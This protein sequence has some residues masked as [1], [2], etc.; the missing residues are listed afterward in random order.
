MSEFD[1]LARVME[2]RLDPLADSTLGRLR[3]RVPAWMLETA[4]SRDEIHDFARASLRTQLHSFRSGVLPES[5]PEVDAAGAMAVAKMGE[6]KVLLNAYRV[7]QMSLWEAWL[8]LVEASVEGAEQRHKLLTR[9]SEFFSRYAGLLSDYVADIYQ[10][11]LEHAARD[12]G[13]RRLHAIRG[14]LEGKPLAVSGLDLNLDQYH[15]GLVAWGEAGEAAARELA[16]TLGRLLLIVEPMNRTW[17]GW[18][19]GARPFDRTEERKLESFRPSSRASIALGLPAFG[20]TG[21]RAT[22]HQAQRARW[23]GG[24]AELSVIRYA[25]VAIESLAG[26]NQEDARAF[27][28]REL[29]GISDDSTASKRLRETLTAYFAAGNNAASAAATLG[30]HQQTVANRLRT[31]EDRLG[32]PIGARRIELEVALRL[33]AAMNFTDSQALRN[34]CCPLRNICV[35]GSECTGDPF[36]TVQ[37]GQ[38]FPG[39]T[40]KS[41][42]PVAP[43]S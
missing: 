43:A 11:E 41:K 33:R 30:V 35:A 25:D 28:D 17:W 14:L 15:L 9:G 21:F 29:R 10:R 34:P 8:D 7:C 37:G 13:G 4:F 27:V 22:H 2:A 12:A 20:E 39:G 31:V 40:P 18:I 42:R 16:A 32:H 24:R 5:C 1:R 36:L 23:F 38:P 6:L 19:C 26:E 3:D